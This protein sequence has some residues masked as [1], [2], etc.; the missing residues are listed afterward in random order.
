MR[1]AL[2][3]TWLIILTAMCACSNGQI[4]EDT[5]MAVSIRYDGVVQTLDDAT[6]TAQKACA[7]H[8]KT[9]QLQNTD[10]KAALERFAHFACVG[11]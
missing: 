4:I 10:V 11:G 6:A 9:A 5:P 7:A 8:G 1:L 3:S 2:G